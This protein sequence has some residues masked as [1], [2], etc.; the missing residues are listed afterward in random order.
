MINLDPAEI[1]QCRW[2]RLDEFLQTQNHP[3][4]T[5]VLSWSYG[6]EGAEGAAGCV[7]FIICVFCHTYCICCIC[8]KL[9]ITNTSIL[10]MTFDWPFESCVRR[11][12]QCHFC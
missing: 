9:T 10:Q 4:I 1:S 6:L 11:M 5:A 7:L 2:M 3:L 8:F 12:W